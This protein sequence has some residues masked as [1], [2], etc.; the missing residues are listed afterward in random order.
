V[1]LDGAQKRVPVTEDG[2]LRGLAWPPAT[3][4]IW[5]TVRTRASDH[6]RL[7]PIVP[8]TGRTG[9][10]IAEEGEIVGLAAMGTGF[11]YQ[12]NS[13]GEAR[14]VFVPSSAIG[15]RVLVGPTDGSTVLLGTSARGDTMFAVH[16]G[17]L[18]PPRFTELPLR[19]GAMRERSFATAEHQ[20]LSS[21]TRI[22]LSSADGHPA[23]AY[24]WRAPRSGG[25]ERLLILVHGGPR[26]QTM[27]TWYA[28]IQQAVREGTSVI[29][30]NY[31]GS[32][33]YGVAHE[34]RE[35]DLSGQLDDIKAAAEYG[36]AVLGIPSRRIVIWGHSHGALLV[37]RLAASYPD[38][39]GKFVLISLVPD[40]EA[41]AIP[42]SGRPEVFLFQGEND[43]QASPGPAVAQLRQMFGSPLLHRNVH[44]SL[45]PEEG[46]NFRRLES[47]AQVYELVLRDP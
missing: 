35:L 3:D 41:E 6:T 45:V 46:H 36:R 42:T 11:T 9:A 34:E 27:R 21:S 47:G 20:A 1:T 13:D 10:A 23:P 15:R 43:V 17:R 31:R 32:S 12:I 2:E 26:L 38:V 18:T 39:A 40:D 4:T 30:V 44:V 28:G 8:A 16:T 14:A 5:T 7:V 37:A 29:A 19:S 33:G 22:D 25:A 24:L